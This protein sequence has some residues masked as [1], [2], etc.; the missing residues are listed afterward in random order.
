MPTGFL[1]YKLLTLT[2]NALSFPVLRPRRRPAGAPSV[3]VLLPARNEAGNLPYTLPGLLRQGALEVLVLDDRSDDD[4]ARI[5]RALGAAVLPGQPLPDGWLGK[6]WACWQLAQQARGEV[7]I[8][9]DADVFWEPGALDAIL[10]ELERTRADLLSVWP[11]QQ[12]RS[13]GERLLVPLVDNVLLTLLPGPLTRL[14]LASLSAGNGQLMAFRRACYFRISGH[15]LVQG[16]VLEDVRFSERLKARGGRLALALGGDLMSVR[17]YRSYQESLHGFAK[18]LPEVH[19]QS[20]LVMAASWLLYLL[21]YTVPWFSR[22]REL[23]V[24]GLLE[25]LLVNVRAGR[26]RPADLLE[27]LLTPLTPLA[28][29]PVYLLATRRRY[30]WKGREYQR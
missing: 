20:R 5:A 18:S 17:M 7:L 4:T 2:V 16:E 14:P 19:A 6:P 23:A 27:V 28:A 9:T 25:R 29:L 13:L 10:H 1:L 15:R 26:T 24:L 12:T 8:F 22:R 30:R 3:S 21:T 11:R